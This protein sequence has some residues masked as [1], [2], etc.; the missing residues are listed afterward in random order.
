MRNRRVRFFDAFSQGVDRW[1]DGDADNK[2]KLRLA[3]AF[4]RDAQDS[5]E[6]YLEDKLEEEGVLAEF[7]NDIASV[8]KGKLEK[9]L[10]LLVK[11]LPQILE[12]ILPL[13]GLSS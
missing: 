11:Y 1:N 4:N 13:F 6:K 10:E 7:D 8:D 12:I 3:L 9:F 5:V 2:L